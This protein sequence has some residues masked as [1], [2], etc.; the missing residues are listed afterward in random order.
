MS[1]NEELPH[2]ENFGKYTARLDR[3]Q[4][5]SDLANR[6]ESM[7]D[8][9]SSYDLP[10]QHINCSKPTQLIHSFYHAP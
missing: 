8:I 10:A 1:G 4:C 2:E 7:N 3:G 6:C 9:S 5:R